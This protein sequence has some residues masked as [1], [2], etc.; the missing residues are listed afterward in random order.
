MSSKNN[1]EVIIDG[2]IYTLCGYESEEYLQKIA[3][4]VNNK[5]AEFKQ[6][7]GFKRQ[8]MDVQRT[9]VNLNLADE[10]FK[11]K[12]QADAMAAELELKDKQLYEVKHEL[13]AEQ[14][15]AETHM[16]ENAKNK[17]EIAE[18]QKEIIRLETKLIEAKE[19]EKEKEK[20]REKK[21][22]SRG[23]KVENE[24]SN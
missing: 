21:N 15:K 16:K 2:K 18:L 14:I 19:R 13:V 4:F 10:Y 3:A 22:S 8:S 20:E 11:V 9:L 24:E 6:D 1:A 17:K 12:K 5:I 7:E 23:R